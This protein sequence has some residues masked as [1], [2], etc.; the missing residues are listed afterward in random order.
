MEVHHISNSIIEF[1][2]KYLKGLKTLQLFQYNLLDWNS[3]FLCNQLLDYV[4]NLYSFYLHVG[5]IDPHKLENDLGT[6]IDKTFNQIPANTKCVEKILELHVPSRDDARG[7]WIDEEETTAEEDMEY[8]LNLQSVSLGGN[9][10]NRK[11]AIHLGTHDP[12]TEKLPL[13]SVNT[14]VLYSEEL[15]ER[16]VPMELYEITYTLD[17]FPSVTKFVLQVPMD[18]NND[19][20]IDEK[21]YPLVTYFE[22][23]Y[24]RHGAMDGL[25]ECIPMFPNMTYLKIQHLMGTYGRSE[26]RCRYPDWKYWDDVID[27]ND[28]RICLENLA[29]NTLCVDLSLPETDI[30]LKEKTEKIFVID[31]QCTR[32]AK[33]QLYTTPTTR[34]TVT[35]VDEEQLKSLSVGKECVRVTVIVEYIETF[36][37]SMET[38]WSQ[39]IEDQVKFTLV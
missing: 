22:Y 16:C 8:D 7:A 27:E 34:L 20:D 28:V 9:R 5:R 18:K 23:M 38:V 21:T 19:D 33:R 32:N 15:S 17:Q 3:N 30:T 6:I 2:T 26:V 31:V 13:K 37:L 39:G 10:I 12:I 24:Y 11:L 25:K 36:V 35:S 14:F 1:I 29:V 4:C